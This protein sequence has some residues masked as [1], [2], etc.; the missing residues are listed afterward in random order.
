MSDSIFSEAI[1]VCT[2]MKAIFEWSLLVGLSKKLINFSFLICK[3]S[4]FRF[5]SVSFKS[6]FSNLEILSGSTSIPI[7]LKPPEAS[8]TARGK[9]M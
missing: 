2:Q 7:T 8:L 6:F 3:N 9:P 4:S 1:G 5:N